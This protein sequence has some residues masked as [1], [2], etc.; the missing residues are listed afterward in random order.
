TEPNSSIKYSSS[1][2]LYEILDRDSIS[3]IDA[4]DEKWHDSS[5]N[6][7]SENLTIWENSDNYS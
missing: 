3:Q 7:D 1:D 4:Y 6:A 5:L 2:D